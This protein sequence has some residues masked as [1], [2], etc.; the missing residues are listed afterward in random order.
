MSF[1]AKRIDA[2][3]ERRSQIYLVR[4]RAAGQNC[5][6][7]EDNLAVR[8]RVTHATTVATEAI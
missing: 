1:S 6:T 7:G 8:P 5:F 3:R 2:Y 4:C